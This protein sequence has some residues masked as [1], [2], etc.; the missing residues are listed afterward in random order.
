MD[1]RLNEDF[2]KEDYLKSIINSSF[3]NDHVGDEQDRWNTMLD[4]FEMKQQFEVFEEFD[5]L[6]TEDASGLVLVVKLP[7]LTRGHAI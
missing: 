3:E 6:N 2:S 7:L 4:Q 5:G 1:K